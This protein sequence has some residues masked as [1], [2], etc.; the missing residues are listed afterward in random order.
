MTTD[1]SGGTGPGPPAPDVLLA[2]LESSLPSPM[3]IAQLRQDVIAV[4]DHPLAAEVEPLTGVRF[5]DERSRS[6]GR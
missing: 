2:E 5:G 3:R 6:V 1:P 4:H